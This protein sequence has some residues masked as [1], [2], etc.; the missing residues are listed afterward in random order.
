MF[1]SQFNPVGI[2]IT[3]TAGNYLGA[4]LNYFVGLWGDRFILSRVIRL[5]PQVRSRAKHQLEKFGAPFLFFAWLPVIGDPITIAAGVL[6]INLV[7]FTFWVVLGKALR[8]IAVMGGAE[9]V[10]KWFG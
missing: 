10:L 5:S 9:A 1:L 6:K 8:Y 4:L 3:A 2:L 7:F